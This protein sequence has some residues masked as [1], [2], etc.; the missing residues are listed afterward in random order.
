MKHN[1]VLNT[2]L[3][4]ALEDIEIYFFVLKLFQVKRTF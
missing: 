4:A 1:Y 2:V 3:F